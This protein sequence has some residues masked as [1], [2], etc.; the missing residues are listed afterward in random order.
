MSRSTNTAF[1]ALRDLD[2]VAPTPGAVPCGASVEASVEMQIARILASPDG[3]PPADNTQ[4]VRKWT[5]LPPRS[6]YGTLGLV[7]SAALAVIAT[8]VWVSPSA[9]APLHNADPASGQV[10]I[11]ASASTSGH[12]GVDPERLSSK[13]TAVVP[14]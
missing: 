10:R 13:G 14:R 8:L 6:R 2:P 9:G 7:A 11:S 12:P 5:D 1:S 4:G 3:Q